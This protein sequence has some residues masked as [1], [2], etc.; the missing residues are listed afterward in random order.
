[1]KK[2]L[3]TTVAV[4]P[5]FVLAP[6]IVAQAR[7]LESLL[8]IHVIDAEDRD[9]AYAMSATFLFDMAMIHGFIISAL[10]VWW[11]S[12]WSGA[13][14]SSD[15]KEGSVSSIGWRGFFCLRCINV[16][17]TAEN[18]LVPTG[19]RQGSPEAKGTKEKHMATNENHFTGKMKKLFS[20]R[21][22]IVTAVTLLAATGIIIAATVSANKAKKPIVEETTPIAVT[23]PAETQAT[24]SGKEEVTI[25]TY[26]GGETQSVN[27]EPEEP[28][29]QFALPVSGQVFKGHD[30]TLQVYSNTMGDYRVHLGLDI[31]T[32]PEAPVYAVAD[33]TVEK[34]WTDAMMGTCVAV[35][36]KDEVVSI[37]KNLSGTLADGIAVGKT[38][39]QGQQLGIV[40]DTAVVEMADEPHLHFEMTSQGLSVD[41]MG[42][43]SEK[44]QA[45]L[46][47]DTAFESTATESQTVTPTETT[48]GGK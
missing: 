38:V 32:A 40:G 2:L 8:P 15:K 22:V 47:Q 10:V 24:N 48:R 12:P 3:E 18:T 4:L 39:K 6:G 25:P 43:F 30:S 29:A 27:A 17:Q 19:H 28:A 35:S 46:S 44:D 41:P 36:H 45:A 42:Y 34:V 37:Y 33:G 20:N 21:A 16:P 23:E 14:D 31:A 11:P 26:N 13:W 5:G 9:I 1:M 7:F